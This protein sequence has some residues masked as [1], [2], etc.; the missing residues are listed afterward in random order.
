MEDPYLTN[1]GLHQLLLEYLMNFRSSSVEAGKQGSRNGFGMRI[2]ESAIT[3]H[4]LS[5]SQFLK[6]F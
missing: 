2:K 4:A 6:I 3:V 1:Y 5:W